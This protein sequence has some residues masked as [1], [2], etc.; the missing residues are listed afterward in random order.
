MPLDLARVA[1][2]MDEL[3]CEIE[4][5]G[6]KLCLDPSLVAGHMCELQAIDRIAQYQRA[7]GELLRAEC[8]TSAAASIGLDD[9]IEQLFGR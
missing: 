8:I 9:L 1:G 3:A 2:V 4:G 6:H 5:L 7:L